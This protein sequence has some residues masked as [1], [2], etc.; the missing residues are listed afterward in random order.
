MQN[1]L[2][3]VAIDE[4][5]GKTDATP[6][7]EPTAAAPV[8]PLGMKFVDPLAHWAARNSSAAFFKGALLKLNYRTG[9]FTRGET[10]TPISATETFIANPNEMIDG[11]LK[12]VDGKLMDKDLVR[13]ADGVMPK[14]LDELPDRDER[15]WPMGR[16]GKRRDPWQR[17]LYLPVKCADGE[18]CAFSAT[19]KSAI[20][21]V[22]DFVAMY[23]RADRDGKLPVVLF[24][25]RSYEH[26]EYG[27]DIFVPVLRLVGW[28]YWEPGQPA[29]PVRPIMVP[30]TPSAAAAKPAAITARKAKSR[31]DD[32]DADDDVDEI[33]F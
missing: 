14:E 27:Y 1:A 10:K 8:A 2:D 20:E 6:D 23:R 11:W 15:R 24:S 31:A 28:D 29:P 30:S 16:D 7:T 33:P 18:V 3:D 19:G 25:S 22:A 4:I 9:Q 13:L 21:E 17:A 5:D 26:K 32:L 12:F